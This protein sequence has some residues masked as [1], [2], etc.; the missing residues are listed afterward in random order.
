M[1]FLI[2][3]EKYVSEITITEQIQIRVYSNYIVPKFSH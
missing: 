3:F 2:I 1:I